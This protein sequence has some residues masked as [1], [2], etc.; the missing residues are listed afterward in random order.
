MFRVS[1]TVERLARLLTALVLAATLLTAVRRA[2]VLPE[3]PLTEDGYYALTVSRNLALGNGLTIDGV[4]TTNG[5]QPM[6][7]VI[8]A[9]AYLPTGAD[10]ITSLRLVL[11]ISWLVSVAAA[12]TV[13]DLAAALVPPV[14]ARAA[15]VLATLAWVGCG[16]TFFQHFNG[17]ETGLA[18]LLYAVVARAW[19]RGA[20]E[21]TAGTLGLGVVLGLLILARIDGVL[22]VGGLCAVVAVDRAVA[23]DTRLARAAG[24]GT[25][26]LLVS[27]PWWIYNR[28]GFGSFMP[29]S[30]RAQQ[31]WGIFPDRLVAAGDATMMALAP[32]TAL[33]AS[34]P[35]LDSLSVRIL[36]A[37]LVGVLLIFF[38]RAAQRGEFV[39][40]EVV[41]G[42]LARLAAGWGLF[43]L[44]LYAYYIAGSLAI[45]HYVR[46]LAPVAIPAAV[47][48]GVWLAGRPTRVQL[49]AVLLIPALL[50][51]VLADLYGSRVWNHN[52]FWTYQ[53]P[54]VRS[55]VPGA[56]RVASWQ[57]GTLGYF[58]HR[59]LNLDGKVNPD[60]LGRK[61]DMNAYLREQRIDWLVDWP[62]N[63]RAGLKLAGEPKDAGWIEVDAS[64]AFVLYHRG[65][66]QLDKSA[67]DRRPW[68]DDSFVVDTPSQR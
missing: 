23:V 53:L 51:V 38:S 66:V 67:P 20:A 39:P 44:C 60:V 9:L 42:R 45:W 61:D 19:L 7:T 59:V 68:S 3:R 62:G 47:G 21:S 12:L 4:H 37:V 5:F 14:R 57:S 31:F 35:V 32:M 55:H 65:A 33:P 46:Y 36:R 64:G 16:Y 56:D 29:T 1:R 25:V 22:L 8:C 49:A 41:R 11:L 13:G 17:L 27:S 48:F 28:V 15:R 52:S 34:M 50:G 58:R 18:L 6:F 54:L 2:G 26:A 43:L 24:M 40:D 30:G 63:V 10:S